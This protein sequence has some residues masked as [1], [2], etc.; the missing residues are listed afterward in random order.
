MMA[1]HSGAYHQYKLDSVSNDI[2]TMREITKL[3]ED[4]EW[5]W[6]A[7]GEEWGEHEQNILIEIL[8]E[9]KR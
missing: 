1:P 4:R 5:I 7:L 3:G 2:K 8:K 9:Y 6:E